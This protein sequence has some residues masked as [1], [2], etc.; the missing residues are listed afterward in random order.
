MLC[1][2]LGID[3]ARA[4]AQFAPECAG[5]AEDFLIGRWLNALR[6]RLPEFLCLVHAMTGRVTDLVR[7]LV[8]LRDVRELGR[9]LV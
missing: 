2:R 1:A 6:A 3:A 5:F 9:L 7:R 4:L 8:R